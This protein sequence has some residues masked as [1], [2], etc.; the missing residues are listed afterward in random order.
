M[1]PSVRTAY[2]WVHA[3]AHVLRNH[4]NETARQVK[5]R[6]RA[7]LGAMSRHAALAGPLE[8]GIK[9]FLKVTASY[10]P[11]LFHCYEVPELPRTNNDLEHYFGSA[12][13]NERRATGRKVASPSMVLR[14]SVKIVA[15]VA[16]RLRS[17]TGKELR[18]VDPVAW[19]SLRKQL[20]SRRETR[21]QQLRFRRNPDRYLRRLEARLV[22]SVLPP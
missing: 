20:D 1:W 6:L 7:L 18:P 17:F 22:Q 3:A 12:R 15:S 9:H 4:G 2:N 8:Q 14:G 10:W 19:S 21:R 16:T 5:R 13:Y 11:G